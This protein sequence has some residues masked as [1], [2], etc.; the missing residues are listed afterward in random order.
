[1]RQRSGKT[2]YM[3]SL[4]IRDTI[5]R[6]ISIHP[7]IKMGII[8]NIYGIYHGNLVFRYLFI[9]KNRTKLLT[10]YHGRGE[11]NEDA[12][13]MKHFGCSLPTITRAKTSGRR[14]KQ[15]EQMED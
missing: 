4:F 5:I 1:M 11:S 9:L 6:D 10:P 7:L 15:E 8:K 3:L 12:D 13:A 14:K 2:D